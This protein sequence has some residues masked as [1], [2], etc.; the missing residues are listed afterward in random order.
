MFHISWQQSEWP[1]EDR[2]VLSLSVLRRMAWQL[3][4]T[5]L[6]NSISA[7]GLRY[8]RRR[9]CVVSLSMIVLLTNIVFLCA[10]HHHAIVIAEQ[11]SFLSPS[12]SKV[13]FVFL[14]LENHVAFRFVTSGL[15]LFQSQL[16]RFFI[17]LDLHVAEMDRSIHGGMWVEW[18]HLTAPIGGLVRHVSVHPG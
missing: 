9:E 12:Q 18:V 2:P 17:A 6:S 5:R 3:T 1:T 7:F 8:Q 15:I 13:P 11:C 10:D 16:H 4:R 14:F